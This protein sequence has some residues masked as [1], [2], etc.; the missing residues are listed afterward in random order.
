MNSVSVGPLVLEPQMA[1]HAAEMFDVLSDPAIYE[2][3]NSPPESVSWLA[4][5]FAKLESRVSPDGTDRWLNWVIRLPSG[6]LAG[7]VQA[8]ITQDLTA[9]V[10]YELGSKFWRQ[11]I[12]SAAVSGML[13]ELVMTYGVHVFVATLKARNYR[14]LALLRTLGFERAGVNNSDEIVVCKRVS[15]VPAAN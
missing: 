2:F 7:Y 12:G 8:T 5:R 15:V 1:A 11:G 3:E 13:K 9:H 4:E 6:V 10:A 14:S